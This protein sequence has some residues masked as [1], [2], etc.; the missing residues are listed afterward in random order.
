[1]KRG[2][3]FIIVVL[4]LI[5]MNFKNIL[6]LIR[7]NIIRTNIYN[8]SIKEKVNAIYKCLLPNL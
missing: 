7:K 2:I 3:I 5:K 6:K 1:M 4:R 8:R